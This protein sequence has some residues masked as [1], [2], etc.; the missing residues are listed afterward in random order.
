METTFVQETDT[1]GFRPDQAEIDAFLRTVLGPNGTEPKVAAGPSNLTETW[2]SCSLQ[3][4]LPGIDP[5][6]LEIE[7][8]ARTVTVRGRYHV[9]APDDGTDVW[10]DI[11]SGRFEETYRLPLEVDGDRAEAQYAHGILTIRM[12]KV[13]HL[14]PAALKVQVVD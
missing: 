8:V 14:K 13:A 7:I 1:S 12:P 9:P 4:A 11:P 2:S 3:V 10:R 6:A 5:D